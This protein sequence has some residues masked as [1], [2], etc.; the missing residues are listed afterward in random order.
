M[1]VTTS[2][3]DLQRELA[4]ALHGVLGI[5]FLLHDQLDLAAEDAAAGIDAV[6]GELGAA[7]ARFTDRGGDSGLGGEHAHLHG[8]GLREGGRRVQSRGERRRGAT[9]QL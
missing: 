1:P 5:G 3:L 7:Q 8:P 9:D 4:E 2:T 6:D